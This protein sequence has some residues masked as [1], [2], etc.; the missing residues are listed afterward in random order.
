MYLVVS[1]GLC[2]RSLAR[3]TSEAACKARLPS[4]RMGPSAALGKWDVILHVEVCSL[5]I[6]VER[7]PGHSQRCRDGGL[8]LVCRPVNASKILQ[9][10]IIEQYV[11]HGQRWPGP[12]CPFRS[13]CADK[14]FYYS[15][16]T[17][18]GRP[19][20]SVERNVLCVPMPPP[21]CPSS[22]ERSQF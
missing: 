17:S 9:K 13:L 5:E 16:S 4:M 1:I 8:S 10:G 2:S 20:I 18:W 21:R 22:A 3:L 19:T 14:G 15:P 12:V 11:V 6:D 7:I